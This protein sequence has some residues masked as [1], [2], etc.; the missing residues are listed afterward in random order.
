[1][2]PDQSLPQSPDHGRFIRL[3]G[4]AILVGFLIH[5]LV[6]GVLKQFPPEDPT[7][8]ELR[9]YLS[10]EAGTWA[11]VHGLRYVA[12]SC[13]AVFAAALYMRTCRDGRACSTGWGLVGLLGAG[14]HVT[15]GVI[16]NGIE[17]L[18]F[19]DFGLLSEEPK[20]FWLVFYLTRVLFTGETV[21]WGLLIGGFS[22]AGWQ[23]GTLPR[24][25]TIPGVLV[26][27]GSFGCSLFIVSILEDGG[28][29]PLIEITTLGCLAWF[30]TTGALLAFRGAGIK[31]RLH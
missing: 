15:S 12:F 2:S 19:T 11:A 21:A 8:D 27:I 23:S 29:V 6:N 7:L 4:V 13:I 5:M 1:M 30:L 10:E 31:G 22:A 17:T 18:A 20:L 28:A 26:A 9:A 14:V 3:G 24:W 16:T 25:L